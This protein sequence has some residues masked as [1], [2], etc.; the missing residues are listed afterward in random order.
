MADRL[1]PVIRMKSRT[2]F[3]S[4]PPLVE[5]KTEVIEHDS[6]GVKA[7]T[8]RP[9]YRNKLRRQVQNLAELHFLRSDLFL[10]GLTFGDIGH[11]PDN[12]DVAG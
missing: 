6:V 11:R 8:I 9:V 3:K 2:K 12:F 4:P 1:F 5:T 7:F 10:G